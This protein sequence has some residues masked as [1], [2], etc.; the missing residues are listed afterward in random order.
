[1][2]KVASFAEYLN[3]VGRPALSACPRCGRTFTEEEVTL[4]IQSENDNFTGKFLPVK[5]SNCDK[6]MSLADLITFG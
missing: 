4:I 6:S 2:E 1:M 5:C 3:W